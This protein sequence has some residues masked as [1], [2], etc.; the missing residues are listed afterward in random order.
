M[1]FMKLAVVVAFAAVA[2]GCGGGGMGPGD[3]GGGGGTNPTPASVTISNSTTGSFSVA[4]STSFQPAD[5][6]YQFFQLNPTAT[7]T[8]GNLGSHHVR[9]QGVVH[10]VPQGSEGTSSTAW[11]FSML[12]A[13]TQPVLST[14]DHSPEFQIAKAPA[15]MYTGNNSG[16]SFTDTSFAGFAEYAQNLVRYYNTGGF[17][18]DG[19]FYESSGFANNGDKV[20]WWG[21]YNEPSINNNLDAELYTTMYNALVP[22]MRAVDPSI[23]F[24]ALE[25][26]CGSENWAAT[27]A[28]GVTAQVDVLA[29]HYYS[30][31]NQ[32]DTDAMVMAT[33][34]GFANSVQ[35]IYTNVLTNPSLANVPVWV[36]ENNVNA[37]YSNNGMS[38]CNPGQI[39][40]EDA[41]GSSPFFAAWRP[42]VFSQLGR[43]GARALYHWDFGADQ[44]YGEV[45]YS[46]GALQLS[47]WVDYWLGQKL[48]PDSGSQV[49]QFT[50][51]DDANLETLPVMN[52]DGS[53]VVMVANHAVKSASDNNGPGVPF[54]V[55]VDVSTLG[56]FSSASMLV[57]DKD[58]SVVNGPSETMVSPATKITM[59]LNGYSVGILT[60]K[61]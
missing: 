22:A 2:A 45:D 1:Q 23:K 20:T 4:M 50:S 36:T 13:I 9:L 17:T 49:L 59:D 39:F 51:S 32:T 16:S 11:D 14:G 12:D 43:A 53:V 37:D 35:T 44:Q 33:V 6:D 29:T 7:T 47:Y 5:W 25:L 10:G 46:T 28:A 60:L 18:A 58:T 19:Q 61:H 31:C 8:L 48:P 26:C 34:P 27:F 57:I 24:A 41:R 3:G 30:S 38:N 40:V 42:Y 56:A 21:I 54:S 55:T 52:S 15:F